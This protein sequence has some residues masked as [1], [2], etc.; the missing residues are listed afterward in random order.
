MITCRHNTRPARGSNTLS[1]SGKPTYTKYQYQL[2]TWALL[3]LRNSHLRTR[4]APVVVIEEMSECPGNY[5]G[6]PCVSVTRIDSRKGLRR[7]RNRYG[8]GTGG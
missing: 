7:V 2:T 3:R 1:T 5:P 4:L 6:N 8:A